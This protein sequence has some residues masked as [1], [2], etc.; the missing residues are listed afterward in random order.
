MDYIV[1]NARQKGYWKI[2]LIVS[3]LDT[4]ALGFYKK[5]GFE[6]VGQMRDEIKKG[7]DG[8]LLSYIVGYEL[9]PNQ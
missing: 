6:T 2:S 4:V 9:H 5:C 8:L 7:Q 3:A 1:D